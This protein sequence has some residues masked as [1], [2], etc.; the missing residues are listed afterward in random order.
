MRS[1]HVLWV[2]SQFSVGF[3]S[4]RSLVD[5]L[6]CC[7]PGVCVWAYRCGAGIVVVLPVLL[8]RDEIFIAVDEVRFIVE[9]VF[10]IM[11]F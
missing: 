6:A 3:N 8:I 5:V 11:C 7:Y 4:T 1:T 10:L 2:Q 9:N